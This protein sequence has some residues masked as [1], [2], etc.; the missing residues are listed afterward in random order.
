MRC[1]GVNERTNDSAIDEHTYEH[2][3]FPCRCW[4]LAH[5]CAKALER[6]QVVLGFLR[7]QCVLALE[8]CHEGIK[9]LF[10]LAVAHPMRV[11]ANEAWV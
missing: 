10:L 2:E 8:L 1:S 9:R 5:E 3:P 7:S 4:R 6:T 11:I